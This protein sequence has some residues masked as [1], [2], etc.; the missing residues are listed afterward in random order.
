MPG[1]SSGWCWSTRLSVL[2][3]KQRLFTLPHVPALLIFFSSAAITLTS[4]SYLYLRAKGASFYAIASCT[5]G[6][7]FI[8]GP[9]SFISI[10]IY[11]L[12]THH[13]PFCILHQEYGYAGYIFYSAILVSTIF[14]MG[15]GVIN[16]FPTKPSLQNVI[17]HL[18]KRCALIATLACT[19]VVGWDIIFSNLTLQLY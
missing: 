4:G 7:V 17:P 12:P 10:Y 8:T 6:I 14:G 3:R 15:A 11:E 18:Q 2:S 16:L 13:C 19:L 5:H 9:I 1:S